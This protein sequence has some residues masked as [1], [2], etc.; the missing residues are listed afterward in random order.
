M[1]CYHACL[2]E[3]LLAK[4]KQRRKKPFAQSGALPESWNIS[5]KCWFMSSSHAKGKRLVT[6]AGSPWAGL[7]GKLCLGW[8]CQDS[9]GTLTL[10]MII[11]SAAFLPLWSQYPDYVGVRSLTCDF[12]FL[13]LGDGL[14]GPWQTH[15][16]LSKQSWESGLWSMGSISVLLCQQQ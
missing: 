3:L 8:G 15:G 5:S 11:Q 2:M 16:E 14:D 10:K 1:G 7:Q 13:W 9:N 12:A 4:M 6:K